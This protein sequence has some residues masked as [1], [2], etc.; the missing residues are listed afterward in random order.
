MGL[1]V[2]QLQTILTKAQLDI[3]LLQEGADRLW[4]QLAETLNKDRDVF[5]VGKS[6]EQYKMAFLAWKFYVKEKLEL[7]CEL[8]T[9]ERIFT[10]LVDESDL[11]KEVGRIVSNAKAP[12]V[13]RGHSELPQPSTSATFSS[14]VTSHQYDIFLTYVKTH[15]DMLTESNAGAIEDWKCLTSLLNQIKGYKAV[16]RDYVAWKKYFKNW[17]NEVKIKEES[18]LNSQ[19][20]DI[21]ETWKN[22]CINKI[23]TQLSRSWKYLDEEKTLEELEQ[24]NDELERTPPDSRRKSYLMIVNV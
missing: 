9:E 19:E 21:R 11:S 2:K 18:E 24:F 12:H 3:R 15:P 17:I 10:V 13:K 22:V 4:E 14:N 5:C 6:G 23:N 20:K 7:D 1:N 8:T 16:K